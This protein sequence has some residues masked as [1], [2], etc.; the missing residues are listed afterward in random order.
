M[1]RTTLLYPWLRCNVNYYVVLF[2]TIVI[3]NGCFRDP[4]MCP[5][6]V[7][8]AQESVLAQG[9]AN[10][11]SKSIVYFTNPEFQ[12]IHCYL[13]KKKMTIFKAKATKLK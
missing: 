1:L 10:D 6:S 4:V 12:K 11:V 5:R 7:I 2:I 13:F 9:N 3:I 8:M